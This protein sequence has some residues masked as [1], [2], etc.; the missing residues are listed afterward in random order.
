[1]SGIAAMTTLFYVCNSG[2]GVTGTTC[3]T[4]TALASSVPVVIWS[5]GA[6][7]ATGGTSTDEAENLD[8]DRVFVSRPQGGGTAGDFDDIVSWIG[9]SSF[10]NRMIAAGQLP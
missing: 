4:A 5:L 6:N 2:T 8:N 10:F 3:G 7:A 9:L 1:M